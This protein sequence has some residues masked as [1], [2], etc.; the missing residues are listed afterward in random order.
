MSI[1]TKPTPAAI[2][3]ASAAVSEREIDSLVKQETDE[4][5]QV[6]IAV[7]AR[8]EPEAPP[9]VTLQSSAVDEPPEST[10]PAHSV[11]PSN[12]QLPPEAPPPP[13]PPFAGFPPFPPG[14]SLPPHLANIPLPGYPPSQPQQGG[15]F[16]PPP[17][18]PPPPPSRFF[19]GGLPPGFG[20]APPGFGPMGPVPPNSGSDGPS[21]NGQSQQPAHPWSGQVPPPPQGGPPSMQ[22][23]PPFPAGGPPLGPPGM[24]G[25]MPPHNM[26]FQGGFG[27]PP[28]SMPGGPPQLGQFGPRPPPPQGSG[29]SI[30]QVRPLLPEFERPQSAKYDPE[31]PLDD[32]DEDATYDQFDRKIQNDSPQ[33]GREYNEQRYGEDGYFDGDRRRGDFDDRLRGREYDQRAEYSD[34]GRRW[35]PLPPRRGRESSRLV[36]TLSLQEYLFY[37]SD[38]IN[39]FLMYFELTRY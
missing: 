20:N 13:P 24:G 16:Q 35:S 37:F 2:A 23:V 32:E 4:M 7:I 12:F 9:V 19:P 33:Y 18:P 5:K 31:E 3:S 22:N 6:D 39:M 15:A 21:G 27:G 26:Q 38:L 10:T 28:S 1:E 25:P 8:S 30:S 34:R 36:F 14:M 17:P 11:V 29:V